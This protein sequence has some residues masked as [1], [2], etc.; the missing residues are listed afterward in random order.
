MTRAKGL[1]TD[2]KYHK[3]KVTV[4]QICRRI[5]RGLLFTLIFVRESFALEDGFSLNELERALVK[6]EE[7]KRQPGG[8]DG[9]VLAAGLRTRSV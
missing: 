4:K 2:V 1:S 5:L 8:T 7:L 6:A 3:V 9:H